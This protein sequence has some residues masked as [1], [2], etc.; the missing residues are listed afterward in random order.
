M[1]HTPGAVLGTLDPRDKPWDDNEIGLNTGIE[2]PCPR[3]AGKGDLRAERAAGNKPELH[4]TRAR[5]SRV[6]Y[7]FLHPMAMRGRQ[8]SVE[9]LWPGA[10]S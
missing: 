3:R 5:A 10:V 6:C 7:L 1:K 9:H 2:L 8:L 4:A